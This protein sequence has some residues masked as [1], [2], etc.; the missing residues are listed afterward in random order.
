M[1]GVKHNEP[2]EYNV[3]D[4]NILF[5]DFAPSDNDINYL[6]SMGNNIYILDHHISAKDRLENCTFANFSMNKSGVGL[7]WEYFFPN[8]PMPLHLEMIQDRDLWQFKIKKT[9]DFTKGLSFMI[10]SMNTINE[11][12]KLLDDFIS[13]DLTT[14]QKTSENVIVIGHILNLNQNMKIKKIVDKISEH[15]HMFRN[16]TVCSYNCE[17]EIISELGDALTSKYCDL[18]VLWSYDH[19]T[20]KYSYSLRSTNK[21]NCAKLA[22]ELI[23]SSGHLNSAGG[24]S[25]LHPDIIFKNLS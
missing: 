15:S 18:A 8:N 21:V 19:I 4:S 17:W 22:E 9:K 6:M 25:L 10:D 14:D 20:S 3:I 16:L 12:L 5:V 23:N 24:T 2:I 11:Q 7:A 1:L 13:N